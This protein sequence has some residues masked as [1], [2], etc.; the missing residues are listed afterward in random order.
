M[1][2]APPCGTCGSCCRELLVPVNGYDIW[3][4]SRQLNLQ[5]KEYVVAL[6]RKKNQE[7][8]IKLNTDGDSV[9]LALAKKKEMRPGNSCVFLLELKNNES[10]CAIYSNR[11]STCRVYPMVYRKEILTI[12]TEALCPETDWLKNQEMEKTSKEEI[13][14]SNLQERLYLYVVES[15][16]RR[17]LDSNQLQIYAIDE[18]YEYLISVYDTFG[19]GVD[20][21]PQKINSIIS[22]FLGNK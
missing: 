17:F 10:S 4:I 8:G 1:I 5:P 9:S 20:F 18:F 16:N 11:P 19:F 21:E 12:H 7:G 15:W 22:N 2:T 3:R 13:E 6:S 14:R